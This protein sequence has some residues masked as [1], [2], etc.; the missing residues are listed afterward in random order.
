MMKLFGIWNIHGQCW[1]RAD[2][3]N[4]FKSAYEI[5]NEAMQNMPWRRSHDKV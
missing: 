4:D 5:A 2:S 1:V 3:G